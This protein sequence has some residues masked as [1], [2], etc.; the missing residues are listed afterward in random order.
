[1]LLH[2]FT[3]IHEWWLLIHVCCLTCWVIPTNV[4]LFNVSAI[5]IIS[6]LQGLFLFNLCL[7]CYQLAVIY[8]WF[9]YVNMFYASVRSK[10]V[11]F[12]LLFTYC[13]RHYSCWF[14]QNYY[15]SFVRQRVWRLEWLQSFIHMPIWDSHI[16]S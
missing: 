7:M 15:T 5:T 14:I 4:T 16:C 11:H 6:Y 9:T 13:L 2:A 12:C 10:M 8:K 1:M 3:K